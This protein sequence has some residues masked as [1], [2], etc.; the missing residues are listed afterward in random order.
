M[1]RKIGECLAIYGEMVVASEKN[2]IEKRRERLRKKDVRKSS[3]GRSL[4]HSTNSNNSLEVLA[5]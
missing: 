1:G 3:K 5:L 2:R 4:G